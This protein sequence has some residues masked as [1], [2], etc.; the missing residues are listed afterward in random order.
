[1]L[2]LDVDEWMHSLNDV[3]AAASPDEATVTGRQT[4]TVPVRHVR[5]PEG[6][7]RHAELVLTPPADA[8]L[9]PVTCDAVLIL[10]PDG[11]TL[12]AAIPRLPTA[13]MQWSAWL[14][15]GELGGTPAHKLPIRLGT[16]RLG[17]RTVAAA[18]NSDSDPEER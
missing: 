14:R 13:E 8:A 3:L 15:V 7:T 11:G 17:K 6:G 4:L 1:M 18:R 12:Q 5:G 10:H 2:T 9:G 16:G